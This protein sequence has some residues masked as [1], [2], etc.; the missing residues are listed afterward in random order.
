MSSNVKQCRQCGILFQSL[1]SNIC[2]N[3]AEELDRQ[4][5]TVKNYLYDNPDANVFDI[6]RDTGVPENLILRFLREGLLTVSVADGSLECEECGEAITS[7][8]YCSKCERTLENILIGAIKQE[9]RKEEKKASSVGRMHV[10][11]N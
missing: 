2:P 6:T 5:H 7:G 10:L 8:R 1:G 9:P 3:C 4:F 11:K